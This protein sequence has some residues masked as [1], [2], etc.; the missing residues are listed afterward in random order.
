MA[1]DRP[2]HERLPELFSFIEKLRDEGQTDKQIAATLAEIDQYE[3]DCLREQHVANGGSAD[4]FDAW[5]NE[6]KEDLEAGQEDEG[7]SYDASDPEPV[8]GA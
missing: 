4:E 5:L 2:Q 1:D 8:G 6:I 7:E 3:V